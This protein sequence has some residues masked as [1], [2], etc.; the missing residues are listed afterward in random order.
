[1]KIF[2]DS[3]NVSS[4]K[5]GNENTGQNDEQTG[6]VKNYFHI[7][8]HIHILNSFRLFEKRFFL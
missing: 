4:K 7:Y 5:K 8:V 1:M 6:S 3:K 2:T